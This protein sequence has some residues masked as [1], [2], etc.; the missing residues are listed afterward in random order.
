MSAE[1]LADEARTWEEKAT[2]AVKARLTPQP[3]AADILARMREGDGG[4]PAAVA[5]TLADVAE[6]AP[7]S[8]LNVVRRN[9]RT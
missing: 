2:L 8:A 9:A 3:G 6:R 7:G 5:A 4:L 1:S